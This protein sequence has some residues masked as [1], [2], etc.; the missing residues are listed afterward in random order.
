MLAFGYLSYVFFG[1]GMTSGSQEYAEH[2][3]KCGQ[4][5]EAALSRLPLLLPSSMEVIA[6]L[7]F[8]VSRNFDAHRQELTL[9]QAF[10]AIHDPRS[11]VAWLFISAAANHCL[12]LGYHRQSVHDSSNTETTAAQESLFWIVYRLEKGIALRLG[13]VSLIRDEE[14]TLSSN[15]QKL[16]IRIAKLQG[17]TYN[18]LYSPKGLSNPEAE[19]TQT[20][21]SLAAEL[22]PCIIETKFRICVQITPSL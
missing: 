10:N 19:R 12:T 9:S 4:Y 8:G 18:E 17:R 14:I 3:E 2:S 16:E 1:Y 11:Q 21:Q 6:A 13:R 22:H 15:P 5:L 7:T 20:A